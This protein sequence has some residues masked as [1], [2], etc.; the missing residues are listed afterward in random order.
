MTKTI[1]QG[2]KWYDW[3]QYGAMLIMSAAVPVSMNIGLWAAALLALASLVKLAAT[4]RLGNPALGRGGT[5]AMWTP[6]LYWVVI[7]VSALLASDRATGMGLVGLKATLLIFPLSMLVTDTSYLKGLHLRL[8]F[9]ALWASCLG[10]FLYFCGNAVVRLV[11]GS[12]L[13]SVVNH[14][15]DPRHH[16]YTAMYAVSALVFAFLELRNHWRGLR[17]WLRWLLLVSLPLLM[18]YIVIVNSRAGMLILWAVIGLAFVA[19]IRRS[20]WKSL[21]F[22]ALAVAWVLGAQTVL[23]NHQDRVKATISAVVDAADDDAADGDARISITKS[24]LHRVMENPLTGYGTGN[25]RDSLVEQYDRDDYDYGA[26]AR[27]NA[28][29]QY[30][31]SMLSSGIIGLIALLLFVFSPLVFAL[32]RAPN[33]VL[34]VLFATGI[35]AGNLLVES[36]LE[37]QMGLLFIGWFMV[38]MVLVVSKEQNKFGQD[39]KK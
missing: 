11:G 15:F 13:A 6:V 23:P 31:E 38:V 27:F 3:L 18:L 21:L 35:V 1:T 2:M 24:A 20:W 32:R 34:P 4:R 37:R 9:Y 10:V 7:L 17:P 25:Y 33:A 28:H 29:N 16:A 22:T 36:M 30:I 8:L 12:T 19:S 14:T 5:I 39:A 26:K